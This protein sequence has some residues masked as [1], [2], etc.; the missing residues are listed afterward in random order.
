MQVATQIGHG[1]EKDPTTGIVASII[2]GPGQ[3]AHKIEVDVPL[4]INTSADIDAFHEELA[5]HLSKETKP[6]K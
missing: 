6:K 2:A 1:A 5:R 4:Q 3:H